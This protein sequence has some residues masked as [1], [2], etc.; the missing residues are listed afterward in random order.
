MDVARPCQLA[1]SKII[2]RLS[3]YSQGIMPVD[4]CIC[5]CRELERHQ[6]IEQFS[7][8][9]RLPKNETWRDQRNYRKMRKS[10]V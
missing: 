6:N 8:S 4:W 2:V 10:T 3:F 1:S 7:K 5:E 9:M